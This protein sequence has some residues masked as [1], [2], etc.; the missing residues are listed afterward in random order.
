[1]HGE[2]GWEVGRLIVVKKVKGSGHLKR[3]VLAGA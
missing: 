2:F 3:G 1:M